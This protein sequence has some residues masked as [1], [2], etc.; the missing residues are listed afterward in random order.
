MDDNSHIINSIVLKVVA[1]CNLNCSYCYEYNR[2]DASWKSKP[3]Q[4]S[5]EVIELLGYRISRYCFSNNRRSFQINLHGGEPLMLGAGGLM[6]VL[7]GLKRA[8]VGIDLKFGMQTNATL[9]TTDIVEILRSF[10]VRVGVSLDGDVSANKNRLDHNGKE[11]WHRTVT[12]LKL[13]NENSLLS[14]IQAVINLDSDPVRVVDTL[15]SFEPAIIEFSQPFGNHDNPPSDGMHRY[16]LSQWLIGAFDH[17]VATSK[18][19]K[20]RMGI[21]SDALVAILGERSNSEWFPS[22]PTGFIVVAT[23]GAYEGLDALKVVGSEG[24]VL[25]L[26]CRDADIQDALNHNYLLLRS[27]GAK[28]C[29]ECNQCPIKDWCH[30]GYLPTR[31]GKGNGFNNPS[32]YCGDIKSIFIHFSQWLISKGNF[33]DNDRKRIIRKVKVLDNKFFEKIDDKSLY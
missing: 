1:P 22:V 20:I 18:Y 14:G 33:P 9:V 15:A 12:G 6:R 4:I 32:I 29:N 25:N 26:S 10:N 17:W 28:L 24:R 16:T 13:L 27:Q 11:S 5:D 19:S 31:Y 3:K 2:G 23:D 7:N 8:V 30:G 21:L